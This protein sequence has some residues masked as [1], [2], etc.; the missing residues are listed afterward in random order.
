MKTDFL[1]ESNILIKQFIQMNYNH[2]KVNL[3]SKHLLIKSVFVERPITDFNLRFQVGLL[4]NYCLQILLPSLFRKE[5]ELKRATKSSYSVHCFS[6]NLPMVSL[7]KRVLKLEINFKKKVF[8]SNRFENSK[9]RNFPNFS[10]NFKMLILDSRIESC[11][12]HYWIN[13][14]S[15][16]FLISTCDLSNRLRSGA[17]CDERTKMRRVCLPLLWLMQTARFKRNTNILSKQIN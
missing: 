6:G 3:F 7:L 9:F 15:W 5:F 4:I 10:E 1:D 2:R 13:L 17:C 11:R 16:P 8:F 14:S 12:I